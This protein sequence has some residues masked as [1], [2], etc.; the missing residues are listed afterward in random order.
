MKC[1]VC[2]E[3]HLF[4]QCLAQ[5]KA[6]HTS[7]HKQRRTYAE[8]VAKL[9]ASPAKPKPQVQIPTTIAELQDL[10]DND[11]IYL[12]VEL[13]VEAVLT[14]KLVPLGF[15]L[16][17]RAS[18]QSNKKNSCWPYTVSILS[19]SLFGSG[20]KVTWRKGLVSKAV[21]SFSNEKT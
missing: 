14:G 9:R 3:I 6:C 1:P 15:T 17:N 10:Q 12:L 2:S 8:V 13:I 5:I 16:P 11:Q 19:L 20:F 18:C 7:V 4:H 21:A